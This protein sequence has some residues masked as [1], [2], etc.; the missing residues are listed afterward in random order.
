MLKQLNKY[1]IWAKRAKCSFMCP[2]VEYLGHRIDANGLHTTQNKVEAITQA[3]APTDL[4]ELRAFSGLL[5]YY[6][7]F[8]PDLATLLHPLNELLKSGVP[9]VWSKACERAFHL[10]HITSNS[11]LLLNMPMLI[12]CLD[13]PYRANWRISTV[14]LHNWPSA[15][16]SSDGRTSGSSYQAGPNP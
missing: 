3:P 9:W 11:D 2:A 10:I 1:G 15:S 4:H 12:C 7:K 8:L 16:T 6:G 14:L 5:H 13:C